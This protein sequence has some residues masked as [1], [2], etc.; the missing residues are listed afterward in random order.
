VRAAGK[1]AAHRLLEAQ[2]KVMLA[3]GPS[4][5][6]AVLGERLS[7][8]LALIER[9]GA[10]D[11]TDAAAARQAATA[12]YYATAATLLVREAALL[13]DPVRED[14]AR[15]I[16]SHKLAPRDPLATSPQDDVRG[17]RIIRSLVAARR[18]GTA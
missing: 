15:L 12:L 17:E 3:P 10:E 8:A 14:M 6:A 4:D 9:A 16:L 13:Q 7:A 5:L 18:G 11:G 2:L 1:A